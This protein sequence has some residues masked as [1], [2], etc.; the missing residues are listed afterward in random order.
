MS[1]NNLWKEKDSTI[2][3][4]LEDRG[5]TLEHFSRKEAIAL[6]KMHDEQKMVEVDDDGNILEDAIKDI[7]K[8][9]LVKVMFHATNENSLPYVP[10]GHNGRAFYIPVEKE[11][12]IPKYILRSC[13]KDAVEERMYPDVG[14]DGKINWRLRK[15]QRFPYTIIQE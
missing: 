14:V 4:E 6:I 3:Q 7:P 5:I 11:V 13:I 8:L 10:V 2:Q 1:I 9:E 15:V 12:D